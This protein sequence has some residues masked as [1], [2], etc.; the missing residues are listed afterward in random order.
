MTYGVAL[1]R[2]RQALIPMLING[3]TG[4]GHLGKWSSFMNLIVAAC[5]RGR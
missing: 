2:L 5:F 3:H 4:G 1:H